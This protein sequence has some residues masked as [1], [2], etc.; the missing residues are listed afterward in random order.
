MSGF[1]HWN[2]EEITGHGP[3]SAYSVKILGDEEMAEQFYSWT[4]H[5]RLMYFWKDANERVE[6]AG[7]ST[8]R[9]R[10]ISVSYERFS[11]EPKAVLTE[12]Q[13]RTGLSLNLERLPE[14]NPS[15]SVFQEGDS[16][17]YEA[18]EKVGLSMSS[19]TLFRPVKRNVAF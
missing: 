6:Q 1:N 15:K 10:Y 16:R 13:Q 19:Q 11:R 14:V 4:A 7:K 12:I 8:F 3:Q 18:A 17:W 5:T 2:I 9:D